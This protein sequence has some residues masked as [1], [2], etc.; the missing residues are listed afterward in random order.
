MDED[1]AVLRK[2]IKKYLD[3][4]PG[5]SQALAAKH[6]IAELTARLDDKFPTEAAVIQSDGTTR[7]LRKH[8]EVWFM[9]CHSDVGGGNDV[10]DE[11]SLS[12]IPFR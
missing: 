2:E 9:G 12:N 4:P 7:L 8:A 6:A 3:A 10:N 5:S 1:E 11:P